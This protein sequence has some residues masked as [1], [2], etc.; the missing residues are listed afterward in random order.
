MALKGRR[1][2]H[3]SYRAIAQTEEIEYLFV[4]GTLRRGFRTPIHPL[5]GR[6]A[7]FC[8]PGWVRGVLFD[9]GAYPGLC[10]DMEADSLVT[11]EVYR[12][13]HPEPLLARLD[14]YEGYGPGFRRPPEYVREM[15]EIERQD[16]LRV[17]AWVYLFNRPVRGA[18]RIRSGDYRRR[19]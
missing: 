5:L 16:G 1:A 2:S 7:T 10:S 11:G 9:L 19:R 18:P 8:G 15:R 4:Y 6:Y 3:D 17:S 12:L 13:D 14:R